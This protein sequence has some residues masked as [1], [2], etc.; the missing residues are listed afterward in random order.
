MTSRA[1][2]LAAQFEAKVQEVTTLIESLSDA[3]WKKVTTAEK[4]PVGVVVHHVAMSHAGLARAVKAIAEGKSGDGI[5]MD[6]LHAM[7]ADH[8]REFAACTKAETLALHKK[9]G[10][11]AAAV[12]RGLTDA[13]LDAK[14]TLIAGRPPASAAQIAGVLC[15]H[16]DEHVGNIRATLGR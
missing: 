10:A 7:N 8:A 15:S 6:A 13:Q 1:E 12:V 9:N 16:V 4:W 14:G 5:T 3:E 2:T 11:A